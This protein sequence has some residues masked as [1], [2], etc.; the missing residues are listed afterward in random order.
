MRL[1][2]FS[3]S[4]RRV[5]AVI[6]IIERHKDNADLFI[7]LGDGNDDVDEA[8]MLYRNI[9]VERVAGNCD[10]YSPHP[11]SKVIEFQGKK[12]LFTHGHPYYVKHGYF[13]IEREAKSVGADFCFFG[14]T[15]IPYAERIGEIYFM[16]PGSCRDG[17]YGIVDIE[18]S[19]VMMYHSK[20]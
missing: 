2:V 13:D 7:F 18:P 17:V 20:I 6:D 9:K 15:H 1:V 12:I 14:H 19:G 10:F 8:L 16:N 3:D 4:H 11:A 5:S